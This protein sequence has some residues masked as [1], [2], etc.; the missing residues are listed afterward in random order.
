MRFKLSKIF[1]AFVTTLAY[2]QVYADTTYN[3]KSV[4]TDEQVKNMIDSIITANPSVPGGTQ[5]S[6]YTFDGYFSADNER[7]MKSLTVNMKFYLKTKAVGIP[8]KGNVNITLSAVFPDSN[9]N[10]PQNISAKGGSDNM[11]LDSPIKDYISEK[12]A[13]I[14]RKNVLLQTSLVEYCKTK[15]TQLKT[16]YVPFEIMLEDSFAYYLD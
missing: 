11:L 6:N 5:L 15:P 3:A 7:Y 14:I 9:C 2:T 12:S 10:N 13:D 1:L 8:V 4:V 16:N